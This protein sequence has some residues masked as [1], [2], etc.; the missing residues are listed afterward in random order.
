MIESKIK[1]AWKQ[2]YVAAL[3]TWSLLDDDM[4]WQIAE[5]AWGDALRAARDPAHLPDEHFYRPSEP[6]SKGVASGRRSVR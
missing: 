1:L 2:D 3:S 4:I 5:E 6:R